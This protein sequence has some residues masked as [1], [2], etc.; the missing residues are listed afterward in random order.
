ALL[1]HLTRFAEERQ[2]EKKRYTTAVSKHAFN[3]LICFDSSLDLKGICQNPQN[4][5]AQLE[6]CRKLF[7]GVRFSKEW[8]QAVLITLK[9]ELPVSLRKN[10]QM[11]PLLSSGRNMNN[12]FQE[13]KEQLQLRF[14]QSQTS[15]LE[16]A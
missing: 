5:L 9:K 6:E 11:L 16:M 13:M 8:E 14:P 12:F 4:Y 15:Q 1:F 3:T 10:V 7:Q 2:T